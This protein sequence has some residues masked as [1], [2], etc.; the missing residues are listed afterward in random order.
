[1]HFF[2]IFTALLL[3]VT[4]ARAATEA[5]FE[6]RVFTNDAGAT[7][8]YRLLVPENYSPGQKYPL[9]L[10]L[11]GAGERGSNN[12]AQLVHGTKL[13]LEPANRAQFPCFVIAPQC[14]TG[15]QWV[16]MQWSGDKGTQPAEPSDAMK[17]VLGILHETGQEFSIDPNRVHVTGLSMGGYGT[18]DLITRFPGRFASGAPICD[19]GDDTVAAKA[20]KVPIWA[21]HSEDDPTVK[22]TR[23]RDM[24]AAI[25]KAGRHP[26]Y[27]E[28]WGLGHNSWTKAYSEPEFLPWMFA[29]RLGQPDTFEIKAKVEPMPPVAV[30][31]DD[32]DM[33]ATGPVRRADWFRKLWKDRRIAWSKQ[34]EKDQGAVV[35]LGDSIT[36][37][38]GD[39]MGDSFP[40]L[41]VAN[42]GISGDTTRGV[43]YR[44]KEDVLDLNPK[45][46]VLL[47][48]TNDLEDGADPELIAGNVKLILAALRK[49]NATMPVIVCKVMPS[50]ATKKRPSD[51]IRRINVLVDEI[52]KSD[53]GFVRC[54]TWTPF[55][56][57]Q[58]D[59]R[60]REFPDLLHPN[61][62]GYAKWAAALRPIFAQLRLTAES[63][64]IIA[65]GAKL[66]KLAG[67]FVFTEGPAVDP[68]GNVYFTDQPN[69][70]IVRWDA[71]TGET[72][73]WLKPAGRANGLYF[74]A[75]GNLLAC[76]D[77]KN[78]L[79]SIAPD[80]TVTV[81]V[82]DFAGNLL[83]GPNDLW[84]RPDGALY[85]TDPL[86]KR[87]YWE[88]SPQSQQDGQHVYFMGPDRDSV[89]RVTIDLPQPNGII[90]TPDGKTLYVADFGDHKTYAY[91][92]QPDGFLTNKRLF[93]P[94]G[95]DGMTIDSEGNVYLTGKGVSVFDKNGKKIE[96]IPVPENWTGNVT[97]A[98]TSRDLLFIT[99]S[100]GIYGLKMRVTGAK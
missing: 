70:R 68:E 93:C 53:K 16:N 1:M 3:A 52:V 88:R 47:I 21:F 43:L 36:Q 20:A 98:G 13:Y 84:I 66:E 18:W 6:S 11:H 39:S 100:K 34:V 44:I 69:D 12:T 15:Q 83:N 87:D 32:V 61:K 74:D 67:G 46:V 22:V 91:D 95:S 71:K 40:G 7:L 65:P 59:A 49:H 38:W 48:G 92:V 86:Y 4:A 14:P 37:G 5:A 90:G 28:Y 10:F 35:F 9:V 89:R 64:G 63:G 26:H 30:L 45:A 73:D 51:K 29:Q 2:R 80:K 23:T 24:I 72:S 60:N 58:G 33:P 31:P 78:Q 97:F 56:D 85:F 54:D 75:K 25:R 27:F 8:P 81:L 79:W 19:G 77:G 17:L 99:A 94:M 76:A 57:D 82:K 62:D 42:R 41:K 55:A 96:Q 50:D